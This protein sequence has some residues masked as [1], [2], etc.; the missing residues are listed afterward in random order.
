[1]YDYTVFIGR[2]QPVHF[3]HLQVI[4]EA[5]E[6]STK[7]IILVGSANRARDIRNP[8]TCRE[9]I[10]M[11]ESCLTMSERS[12]IFFH[13]LNDY[14]YQ[15]S[16][17][18]ESV[19]SIVDR[20]VALH[21]YEDQK[22]NPSIALIGHSKDS[23]GFFLKLFPQWE[24]LTVLQPHP[25]NA[26]DIRNIFFGQEPLPVE[27]Y[28]PKCVY[29]W[30]AAWRWEKNPNTYKE[31]Q[32]EFEHVINYKKQWS[33]TPYPVIFQTV[34]TLVEQSGHV[35]LV[36]RGASPG[37]GKLALPGGFLNANEYLRDG[38]IRELYEETR[39]DVPEKVIRGC[40]VNSHTF[41]DPHR[42]TR[43]RTITNTIHVKLE[44]RASL[45]KVKGSDDAVKALWLPWSQWKCEDTFEDHWFQGQYFKK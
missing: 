15:D 16:Q 2:F 28:L 42:S 45:P 43:G 33:S 12:R 10:A 3:G 30:M 9:R 6:Q 40:I 31:L 5:L 23:S 41:D 8:F 38:A 13:P 17:W 36:R 25:I 44:D 7:L 37:K 22:Y 19:Q 20:V 4:K 39:I 32:E 14:M 11:I 26:T 24:S 35:L 18:V 29:D 34:D 21:E 27:H 1:M